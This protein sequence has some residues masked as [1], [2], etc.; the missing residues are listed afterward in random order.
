MTGDDK[1]TI[2][3]YEARLSKYGYVHEALGWTRDNVNERLTELVSL[4]LGFHQDKPLILLDLGCGL[5]NLYELIKNDKKYN[6][7]GIDINS[8][9][10][11]ECKNRYPEANFFT[12]NE[13]ENLDITPDF[14]LISGVF[15]HVRENKDEWDNMCFQITKYFKLST[16]G[17]V[18]NLLTD[19][20][21]YFTEHNKNYN[22]EE[23]IKFCYTLSDS[24][25]F[26]NTRLR[27]EASFAIYRNELNIEKLTFKY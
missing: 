20:V 2:E 19:R 26:K 25:A 1:K 16:K 7:I 6:Y 11:L 18:W 21:D 3:R 27:Y 17:V 23:V 9:L 24:V 15:N 8:K 12:M 10:I 14:T 4:L 22:V 13:F 5:G